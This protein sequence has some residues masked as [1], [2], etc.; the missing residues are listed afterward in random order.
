MDLGIKDRVALVCASSKGL[1][2]ACAE[3]LAREGVRLVLCARNREVLENTA[4][5]IRKTHNVEVLALSADVADA[6]DRENLVHSAI[7]H[8]GRI[9]ILIN[10]AG[11]P[12]PGTFADFA[13]EDYRRALELNLLSAIDMTR[14]VVPSMQKRNWGRIVNIA[15]IAVKQPIGNLIL[16]NTARTALIGF[17]KTIA[18]E[19]A[20][21]GILV[22]NVCPGIIFTDRIKEL[23]GAASP[24]EIAPGT[25]VADLLAKVPLGRV[26]LPHEF[27]AVA[28]F[29][30]SSRAGYVTGVTLQVDGGSFVGLM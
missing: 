4:A 5:E 11:G 24:A 6:Q 10:N 26:G 28:A 17:A 22:N 19:L 8:Y 30:C 14:R 27:G 7:E 13:V 21:Q 9:D 3:A 16:S 1:G 12:P 18:T 23:T 2:R 20:P 15:S 25:P 29:L